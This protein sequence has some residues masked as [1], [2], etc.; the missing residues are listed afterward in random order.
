MI[1]EIIVG[2]MAAAPASYFYLHDHS[3]KPAPQ[4]EGK[5]LCDFHAHPSKK[6]KLDDIV[7]M[8]GSPG[9][10]GLTA[11]YLDKS[12]DDILLYEE[13]VDIARI[14]KDPAF[15]E[16]TPGKLAR[17][18]R[19]Y[20][21]RTQEVKADV[22]HLLAL[23]WEGEYLQHKDYSSIEEAVKD[24][25]DRKGIAV[26]NHPFFVAR[27][28]LLVQFANDE[29]KE[30]IKRGYS[31]V[32]EVELHNAFCINLVP[33]VAWANKANKL[34]EEL[35]VGYKHHG[36]AGSDCHRELPQVKIVGNYLSEEGIQRGGMA[37]ITETIK[38]GQ[39][40]RYGTHAFGPY[41]SRWSWM[42]GV[43]GDVVA[44]LR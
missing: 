25:H 42:K 4:R 7:D 22:F 33:F 44:A 41:V 17:Y 27:G 43:V 31:V 5:V 38:A 40:E 20:F 26:F 1:L 21:A 23:G 37:G 3:M 28:G 16:I 34:A 9:L 18:K 15:T 35:V 30:K 10:V 36:M 14:K 6:N 2:G 29:E 8:L 39:F 11:K 13:A 32:D 19:G 24:I 12:G